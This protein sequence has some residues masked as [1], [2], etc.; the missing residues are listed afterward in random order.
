MSKPSLELLPVPWSISNDTATVI[1][2]SNSPPPARYT[3]FA[4]VKFLPRPLSAVPVMFA[5]PMLAEPVAVSSP[6]KADVTTSEPAN[7]VKPIFFKLFIFFLYL[8]VCLFVIN[9]KQRFYT[10]I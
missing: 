10:E 6:A 8:F 3:E 1:P 9:N 2:L 4:I 5:T 7:A